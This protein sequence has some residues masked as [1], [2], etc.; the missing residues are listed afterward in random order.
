MDLRIYRLWRAMHNRC[1]NSN[2]KCYGHYGGR[3]IVVDEKWHGK[4]GFAVFLKD[5]GQRP[6][7]TTLD[8]IDNNGPYSAENCRWAT[9]DQQANNKRNNRWITANGKTQ[10]LAQWARDLG[11]NPANILYRIKSGMT[12]E[13]AVTVAVSARP[14]S[15]LTE[16][17]ARYVKE[18]YPVMTSSQLAAKLGVSKKTVLNIIH[19]KTF[20]DVEV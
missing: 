14:N 11:C 9:K 15:K 18:N 3:G 13:Q 12:E 8:R 4:E 6:P 10:T 7:G 1:Y 5:M 20:R 19:G 17:D 2:V 16:A